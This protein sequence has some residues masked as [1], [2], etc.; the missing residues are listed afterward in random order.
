M[1]RT[2]TQLMRE[3]EK[4]KIRWEAIF[5][6]SLRQWGRNRAEIHFVCHN[7]NQYG[8][9]MWIWHKQKTKNEEG[10]IW[11]REWYKRSISERENW[12]LNGNDD[13][14]QRNCWTRPLDSVDTDYKLEMSWA[15]E[16]VR[17]HRVWYC[18]SCPCNNPSEF[19]QLKK[20]KKTTR[21]NF[22]AAERTKRSARASTTMRKNKS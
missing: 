4:N 13:Y 17:F 3:R 12:D 9:D 8:I 11:F 6:R 5:E 16:S 21:M 22:V 19:Q 7:G 18:S 20:S 14:W 2:H 1:K 15:V 10:I